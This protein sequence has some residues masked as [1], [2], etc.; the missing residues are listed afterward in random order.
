MGVGLP[1]SGKPRLWDYICSRDDS[2][3]LSSEEFP[4]PPSSKKPLRTPYG[5]FFLPEMLLIK[6]FLFTLLEKISLSF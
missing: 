2:N 4:I 3:L 6:N 5:L 1:I